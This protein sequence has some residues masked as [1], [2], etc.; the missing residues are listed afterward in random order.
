MFSLFVSIG[1]ILFT[2]VVIYYVGNRFAE[3]SSNLG[4]YFNLPRSVKGATFDAISS[5]FPEL[6]VALFSVIVFKKFEVGIGTIAG[7]A[8]FNLLIIPAICVLV[9]PVV[10]KVGM[11][12]VNRDAKFYLLAVLALLVALLVS[13]VWGLL[14]PIIFLLMYILY[15]RVI[16]SHTT[17]F[18]TELKK[19]K[20]KIVYMFSFQKELFVAILSMII[21]AV[22]SYF[23]TEHAIILAK[24]LN[25]PAII[26]AF[27][28]VAA[29]T[30]V[31]D[32]V[33]SVINARKGD[34]VDATA[35]VF[36]S[37]IFD[38]LVGLSLPLILA[39]IFT[40]PIPIYFT[41]IELIVGLLVA[42]I[43]VF[44]ML[45]KNQM[46]TKRNV[47]VLLGMYVLFLAYVI[48]LAFGA[49]GL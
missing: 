46:F 40:G 19:S 41:H 43:I 34:V 3:A 9:S 16:A 45:Y 21:I 47:Y 24:L 44:V 29:A 11:N 42:T 23:M 28:I 2:S 8:L 1:V 22:A 14:V 7:S 4:D 37:N 48:L 17:K 30:S 38:I 26:V 27:T 31:P 39:Y 10:F 33:I 35:N 6:M 25:I 15:L 49:F 18:R 32:A 36:G 13:K 20:K 5:S 12:V